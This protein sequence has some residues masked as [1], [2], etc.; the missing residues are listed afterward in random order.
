MNN[1][2]DVTSKP[3]QEFSLQL[4]YADEKAQ[5]DKEWQERTGLNKDSLCGVIESIVFVSDRP[6]KIQKIRGKIDHEKKIPLRAIQEAIERLQENYE[7]SH[8]GIRLMEVGEGFQFRTKATYAKFIRNLY[9][10]PSLV[11]SPIALEVLAIVAYKQPISRAEI[12][13]MRG[14][15]SSHLLRALMD[16][17]LVRLNGRSDDIG[18]PVLYGTTGE[19]LEMFNLPRLEDLPPLH[20]LESL[21][22]NQD[23]GDI[24]D[25]KE[26]IHS[27]REFHDKFNFDELEE[28]DE[29]TETIKQINPNTTFTKSIKEEDR[30][31]KESR[32][33]EGKS[34]FDLLEEFVHGP[35]AAE[36]VKRKDELK[37][38]DELDEALEKAFAKLTDDPSDGDNDS[39]DKTDLTN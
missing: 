15:D 14:V 8:H 22:D 28:L 38:E 5:E 16:K 3:E 13:K 37:D 29:L 27:S 30:K 2:N 23:V 21:A 36:D 6:V 10:S 18:R 7:Q 19:F 35:L 4:D 20:E 12:D 11:L 39:D 17:R 26:L 31:R 25:I 33:A 34:A 9:K 32:D 24:S 1:H